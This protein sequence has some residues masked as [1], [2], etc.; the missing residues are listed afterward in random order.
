MNSNKISRTY[1]AWANRSLILL[2]VGCLGYLGHIGAAIAEPQA[3]LIEFWNDFE[4]ESGISINHASWQEILD[5]YLNDEHSS[6][7]NRF[8]YERVSDEDHSKLEAYLVY[9]QRFDPRQFNRDEAKAYWINLYNAGV[10]ELVIDANKSESFDSI[11]ELRSGMFSAGPWKREAFVVNLQSMTLDD[12]QHGVIR[13]L[14]QDHRTHYVLTKASL[15]G[16]NLPKTAL[17]RDNIEQLLQIAEK[18]YLSH[19]RA[20]RVDNDQIILSSLFSWYADDFAE[21][22]AM[23]LE[24]LR[25]NVPVNLVTPLSVAGDTRFEYDWGLNKPN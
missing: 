6:G 3:K 1:Q 5:E 21:D 7:I 4:D 17:T 15:G 13:P 23:F 20:V 16:A 9:L 12:V 19:P 10:V 22:N 14:W 25:S 18:E 2:A 24:Y 8:D 11:R